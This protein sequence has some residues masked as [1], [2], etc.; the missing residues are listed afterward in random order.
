[1]ERKVWTSEER[2]PAK[3]RES[4]VRGV[5]ESVTENI[6]VERVKPH[7]H[8]VK[9]SLEELSSIFSN[10]ELRQ[11]LSE[12]RSKKGNTD[13]SGAFNRSLEG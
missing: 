13:L 4:P 12:A 2:I 11:T 1:M 9:S 3:G 6:P 10:K 5:T 8:R 7:P